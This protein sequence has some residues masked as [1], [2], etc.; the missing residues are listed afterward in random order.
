[1]SWSIVT[2]TQ[3]S[4]FARIPVANMNDIWYDIA[5]SAVER[6]TGFQSLETQVDAPITHTFSGTGASFIELY[7]P[8]VNVTSLRVL[9]VELP[10]TFYTVRWDGIELNTY[11]PYPVIMSTV[12]FDYFTN[13]GFIFPVGTNNVQA[14][15]TY[16]GFMNLPS[17]LQG[18]I[19]M[20]MLLILKELTVPPRN[21]GSDQIMKS[22]GANRNTS[23]VLMI[24]GVH[25]KIQAIL[26]SVTPLRVKWA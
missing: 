12:Y 5:I 7:K 22:Y 14:T 24:G 25:G 26:Q 10:T 6:H 2:K 3:A 23:E 19:K 1:M 8:L 11:R 21:E 4:E 20:A 9:N 16:G 15:F 13:N 17:S 18:T